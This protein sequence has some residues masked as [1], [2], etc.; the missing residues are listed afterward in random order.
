MFEL[1]EKEWNDV[2]VLE[3]YL[4][5]DTVPSGFV[6]RCRKHLR[7]DATVQAELVKLRQLFKQPATTTKGGKKQ[8]RQETK[9]YTP[10]VGLYVY[11]PPPCR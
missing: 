5:V 6:G 4:K 11:Y 3:H 7:D 10:L 8:A 2:P 1:A 9:M